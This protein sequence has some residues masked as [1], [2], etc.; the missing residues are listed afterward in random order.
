MQ[1]IKSKVG[2][3]PNAKTAEHHS[4][5]TP[6][7]SGLAVL[8]LFGLILIVGCLQEQT[9]PQTDA[10][11]TTIS[12]ADFKNI[13]TQHLTTYKY[14]AK[15]KKGTALWSDSYA[16]AI[17]PTTNTFLDC[18][19]FDC[20]I[21]ANVSPSKALAIDSDFIHAACSDPRITFGKPYFL[22]TK[23]VQ[24][25][26]PTYAT[27]LLNYT[28]PANASNGTAEQVVFYNSTVQNGT[29][30]YFEN[31]SVPN[32]DLT[33][34]TSDMQINLPMH[35]PSPTIRADC[36]YVVGG[37]ERRDAAIWDGVTYPFEVEMGNASSYGDTVGMWR[38]SGL[39]VVYHFTGNST[40]IFDSAG[41]KNLTSVGS[42]VLQLASASFGIGWVGNMSASGAYWQD[43]TT[44][45]SY[46]PS[47]NESHTTMGWFAPT[48]G[49]T[50]WQWGG[51]SDHW[52]NGRVYGNFVYSLGGTHGADFAPS[53]PAFPTIGYKQM[54]TTAFDGTK[55]W[56]WSNASANQT[57]TPSSAISIT[58]NLKFEVGGSTDIAG[59]TGVGL[60]DEFRI[61]NRTLQDK[62]V[63]QT[64]FNA[65]GTAGYGNLKAWT[66]ASYANGYSICALINSTN[67]DAG[68]PAVINGSSGFTINGDKQV[69]WFSANSSRYLCYNSSSVYAIV[70]DVNLSSGNSIAISLLSPSNNTSTTNTSMTFSFITNE[71]FGS[72]N[73][74]LTLDG[75]ANATNSSVLNNTQANFAV[76]GFSPFVNSTHYW[77]VT[78]ANA[79]TNAIS[80]T[81]LFNIT[82]SKTYNIG[83]GSDGDLLFTTTTKSYGNLINNTD[84]N[85]SNNTLYLHLNRIYNFG[86]FNMSAGTTLSTQDANGTVMIIKA[87]GTATMLGVLNFT[88]ATNISAVGNYSIDGF[89]FANLSVH[90]GGYGAYG[91]NVSNGFGGVGV[92]GTPGNGSA[93]GYGGGGGGGGATTNQNIPP[94]DGGNGT[95]GGVS[96]GT[97]GASITHNNL[98]C[99]DKGA[100]NGNNGTPSSSGGSGAVAWDANGGN[101][102]YEASAT[103]GTGASGYGQSG[104]DGSVDQYSG[105][106]VGPF[107]AGGGAASG[108]MPGKLSPAFYLTA[109][110]IDLEGSFSTSALAA[111]NGGKQGCGAGENSGTGG[112][113]GGGGGGGGADAGNITIVYHILGTNN[114]TYA[115]SAGAFGLGGDNV[116]CTNPGQNGTA[117]SNGTY[118]ALLVANITGSL[119]V[120]YGVGCTATGS[121]S[122][123]YPPANLAINATILP[124][125]AYSS[126]SVTAGNATI[127][128]ASNPNTVVT[129]YDNTPAAVL[130]NCTK[131]I[132]ISLVAPANNTATTSNSLN[133]SFNT[134]TVYPSTLCN[135]TLDGAVNV[136][137]IFALNNTQIN[138]TISPFYPTASHTW[139][140]TCWNGTVT[141]A[142]PTYNF[143]INASFVA[144]QVSPANGYA[145]TVSAYTANITLIGNCTGNSPS[146]LANLTVNGAVNASNIYAANN[147]NI[148]RTILFSVPSN[149]T[150]LITCWNGSISN[151]SATRYF[152]L[153]YLQ[154]INVSFG[155][156]INA[157]LFNASTFVQKNVSAKNQSATSPLYNV[158][159]NWNGTL[160]LTCTQTPTIQGFNV[161]VAFSFNVS[162]STPCNSSKIGNI[163]A[164]GSRYIW[165]WANFYFPQNRTSN[166]T[167]NI[168]AS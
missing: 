139:N 23:T 84:Y 136:S 87:R 78:C 48:G 64:Y 101:C 20:T 63:N 115:T 82:A 121:N 80:S 112:A 168:T 164:F 34:I 11:A 88:N 65:I 19:L 68:T 69:V 49:N 58:N 111:Q 91:L 128:N 61:Y 151:S 137:G 6:V 17:K 16:N 43:P 90:A 13:T 150:W 27:M 70:D 100:T 26:R 41:T 96:N 28:I 117:G 71:T 74:N 21:R 114:A 59:A 113:G 156:G 73:C 62:E 120:S 163:T 152:N 1:T 147:T 75:S 131:A 7:F 167:V 97:G 153:T 126:W 42:T 72:T 39:V 146:Y 86:N 66:T 129:V 51:S 106:T 133:F 8:A 77:N 89:N 10:G 15:D 4:P 162:A 46:L 148:N 124:G 81:Y 5:P 3:R 104:T 38:T 67:M 160:N 98:G 135:L 102:N 25:T 33:S 47:G 14:K 44:G 55:Q 130:A 143:S 2:E 24:K 35:K 142:S 138:Q 109:N 145:L 31:E 29:E 99:G 45:Y 36:W 122:T 166:V 154:Y 118:S 141:G 40:T 85:V 125:Y 127:S 158:T 18:D 50:N 79:T 52:D 22:E 149:N 76:N 54:L 57:N 132:S 144:N 30:A 161:S 123:F 12:K 9:P 53:S 105:K 95:N 159:S 32:E 119:V 94:G 37:Q 140:V 103:S 116:A 110:K 157:L 165:A 56:V 83:N 108:G 134:S 107:A 92:G 155:S 60:I 93:D